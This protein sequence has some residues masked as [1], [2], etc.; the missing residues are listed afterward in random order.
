MR[1]VEKKECSL[2]I[3][4]LVH[5]IL[6]P[7]IGRHY[8]EYYLPSSSFLLLVAEYISNR[9]FFAVVDVN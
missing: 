9:I 4:R 1:P 8:N 3:D 5:P 7:A 6:L 2:V